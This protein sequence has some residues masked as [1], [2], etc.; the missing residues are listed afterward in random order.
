MTRWMFTLA[1]L[2]ILTFSFGCS[3]RPSQGFKLPPGNAAAGKVAFTQL[4]CATCHSVA[5]TDLPAPN[6][7]NAVVLG[8]RSPMYKTMGELTTAII[9]PS[10][11]VTAGFSSDAG[12]AHPKM[13]DLA[14]RMTVRQMADLVTFLEEHYQYVPLK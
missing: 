10:D 12:P 3:H 4:G 7:T 1:I 9:F 5:G 2:L 8:G 14:D 6:I 13:P 11:A